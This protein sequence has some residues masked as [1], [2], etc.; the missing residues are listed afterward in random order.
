VDFS[1]NGM[2]LCAGPVLLLPR[3]F[4]LWRGVASLESDLVG[5]AHIGNALCTAHLAAASLAPVAAFRPPTPATQR[6]RSA[7]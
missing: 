3:T 4:T 2:N 7:A 6:A 5:I 1:I